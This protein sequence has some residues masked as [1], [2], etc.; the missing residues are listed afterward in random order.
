MTALMRMGCKKRGHLLEQQLVS[1]CCFRLLSCKLYL[2][3]LILFLNLTTVSVETP[4][5]KNLD[6]LWIYFMT[7]HPW[8][9]FE[10]NVD[11]DTTITNCSP[12]ILTFGFRST[13]SNMM[14][15]SLYVSFGPSSKMWKHRMWKLLDEWQGWNEVSS[16]WCEW[17]FARTT[18]KDGM[19]D[20]H[21][22]SP[23]YCSCSPP[24]GW[25]KR[26]HV[27]CHYL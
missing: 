27:S 25:T 7:G 15:V 2:S 18:K 22:S 14:T 3:L 19:N 10:I 20:D 11:T 9:I 4:G 5:W 1:K 24:F 26:I 17:D 23:C 8:E 12:Y 13:L 21:S 16:R 6:S